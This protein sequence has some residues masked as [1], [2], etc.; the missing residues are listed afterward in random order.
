MSSLLDYQNFY[1]VGVK[2]VAMTSIAQCL[3]DAGK[4]V[5]GSDVAADFVTKKILDRLQLKINNGFD[6]HLPAQIQAV[7]YTSA[8]QAKQ[9]PQVQQAIKQGLP[10]YSQAEALAEFFNQKKGVAVCG[11]GGKSTVSAMIT[12]ILTNSKHQ[13]S[14]SVGV[15]E[16]LGL[17]KTGQWSPQS[18]YFIAEADEYVIDPQVPAKQRRPRFSFL[19]PY[20][21][22]CTNL[23][24]DHPDVYQ[25]FA[26]TK[27][28]FKQFFAQLKPNG[29]LIIN[30]DNPDLQELANEQAISFGEQNH[31]NWQLSD[32]QV[33]QGS[34]HSTIKH[35]D[36]SYSLQLQ[37]PGKYNALNAVAAITACQVLGTPVQKALLALAKFRSTKR[38]FEFIGEK[39]QTKY[40]DDYAHHPSEVKAA[41]QALNEWFP[42]RR[43]IIA[44]QP[45]TFSRTKKLFDQFVTAFAQAQEV[46]MID[47]FASAREEFDATISSDLLCK[48]IEQQYP[49]IKTNNLSTIHNLA[50]YLETQ[51]K[52][53]DV[54][55]TLGAGD[56]YEVHDLI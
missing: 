21:T 10:V 42:D 9:N 4:H 30:G 36:Q 1:L 29:K 38:R 46:V 31:N 53:G 37:I 55:L 34:T 16:I 5:Q 35:Q 27:K 17:S 19:K 48:A 41:I 23:K 49:R 43:K 22:V 7:I 11:V 54:C 56:I 44:F 39:N 52:P 47:I 15:G 45:H 3:I 12:W 14:F 33:R 24:F 32:Y 51:L 18:E 26:H 8:H 2:G 40:Y 25:D 20:I 13:P 50:Q 6:H 28:T